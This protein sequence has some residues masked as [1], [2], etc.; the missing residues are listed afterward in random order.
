MPWSVDINAAFSDFVTNIGSVAKKLLEE[1]TETNRNLG[2]CVMPVNS[3][4]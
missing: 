2:V 4:K 3:F 1:F